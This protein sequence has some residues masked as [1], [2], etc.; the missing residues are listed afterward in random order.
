MDRTLMLGVSMLGCFMISTREDKGNGALKVRKTQL[1]H[2]I[3]A[4]T[5]IRLALEMC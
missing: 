2:S 4:K 5:V 1:N 3:R